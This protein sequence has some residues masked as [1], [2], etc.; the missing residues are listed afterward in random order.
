MEQGGLRKSEQVS[1]TAA[2]GN[3]ENGDFLCVFLKDLD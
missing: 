3:Q 1:S 2:Q